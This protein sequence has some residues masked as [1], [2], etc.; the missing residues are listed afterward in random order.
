MQ[1][2]QV[3]VKKT[4]ITDFSSYEVIYTESID[5]NKIAILVL[6][7]KEYKVDGVVAKMFLNMCDEI[8][9]YYNLFNELKDKTGCGES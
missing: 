5:V 8:D 1:K 2:Q 9:I 6:N 4:A 3:L 7:D